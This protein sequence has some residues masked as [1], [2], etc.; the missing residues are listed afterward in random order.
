MVEFGRIWRHRMG[1]G[2]LSVPVIRVSTL[3]L[4]TPVMQHILHSGMA[5]ESR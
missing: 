5:F 4:S 2:D 1:N 3:G